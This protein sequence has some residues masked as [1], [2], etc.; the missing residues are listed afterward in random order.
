MIGWV[1]RKGLQMLCYRFASSRYVVKA[2]NLNIK[3]L[4]SSGPGGQHVN[5]TNSKA[6]IRFNINSCKWLP[7]DVKKR[8]YNA[9][10][11]KITKSGDYVVTSD[12]HREQERNLKSAIAKLQEVVDEVEE[13]PVAYNPKPKK[14]PLHAKE[15]R[16]A[17]KKRD[18]ERIK[19]KTTAG[20]DDD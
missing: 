1:Y 13:E 4:R 18:S 12:K 8:F 20:R 9:Y 7:E 5:K 6:E 16:I 15:R 19:R 11:N 10:R 2:E 14:E 3:Y 17:G